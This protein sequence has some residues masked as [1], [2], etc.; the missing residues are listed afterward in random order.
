MLL[1]VKNHSSITVSEHVKVYFQLIGRPI[2][3]VMLLS[4]FLT[5][6]F[7]IHYFVDDHVKRGFR[8]S[9]GDF[10]EAAPDVEIW[11]A[12]IIQPACQ[13]YE[14]KNRCEPFGFSHTILFTP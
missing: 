4:Y 10:N 3:A 7:C 13:Y 2:D 8:T 9:V 14:D 11:Q 5:E 6:F 1:I 12:L